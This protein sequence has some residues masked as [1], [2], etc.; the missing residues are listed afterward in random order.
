MSNQVQG[1]ITIS[2]A[3]LGVI[4]SMPGATLDLG[5]VKREPVEDDQGT[6]GYKETP[7][8]P[9]IEATFV[10]KGGVSARAI[11]DISNEDISFEGDDGSHYV[12]REAWCSEPP[13]LSA[14]EIKVTF[15]GIRCDEVTA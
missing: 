6:A 1:R 9:K 13:Q 10:K 14:G 4:R 2:T 12:L 7:S 11:G 3:S 5:G 8:T 15:A